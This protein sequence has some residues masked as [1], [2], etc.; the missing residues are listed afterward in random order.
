MSSA[1]QPVAWKPNGG[2]N[3]TRNSGTKDSINDRPCH[4]CG[5]VREHKQK[6]EKCPARVY[7]PK[8][9]TSEGITNFDVRMRYT[10]AELE[11][12][13]RL[14]HEG[15]VKGNA[16]KV[17]AAKERVAAKQPC[18]TQEELDAEHKRLWD[19]IKGGRPAAGGLFW[20][21]LCGLICLCNCAICLLAALYPPAVLMLFC[22]LCGCIPA[23]TGDVVAIPEEYI[24]HA[25][26]VAT[27]LDKQHP[28]RRDRRAFCGIRQL[29]RTKGFPVYDEGSSFDSV[30]DE[31]DRVDEWRVSLCAQNGQD[32]LMPGA[33]YDPKRDW[34]GVFE[35]ESVG[36]AG[37]GVV[38]FPLEMKDGPR[39]RH[40][41]TVVAVKCRRRQFVMAYLFSEVLSAISWGPLA[42]DF[43]VLKEQAKPVTI[44]VQISN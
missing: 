1:R 15:R 29:Q 9:W 31:V 27:V 39:G 8:C 44:G 3:R 42:R 20:R 10:K 40:R 37:V 14:K 12:V 16:A 41:K 28:G 2:K 13:E 18:A 38:N 6:Y 30:Y 21:R 36:H 23:K 4:K 43:A 11:E 7:C 24:A 22:F 25:V 34:L 19:H 26:A 17:D 33:M 32:P 5:A 35:S